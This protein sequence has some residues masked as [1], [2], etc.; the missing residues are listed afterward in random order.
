M[1]AGHLVC[2]FFECSTVFT[3]Q[4][5]LFL[6][7][8]GSLRKGWELN[9]RRAGDPYDVVCLG[10]DSYVLPSAFLLPRLNFSLLSCLI[11]FILS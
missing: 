11:N 4:H 9:Y 8:Q 1:A 10:F 2:G 3:H 6:A 5:L 7:A